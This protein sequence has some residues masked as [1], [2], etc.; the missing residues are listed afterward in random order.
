VATVGTTITPYMQV[1]VQSSV[2]EKNVSMRTYRLE[3]ADVYSGS[4][5]S[6]LI[7]G[8]IIICTGATLFVHHITI[9][10]ADDVARALVPFVGSY[11]KPVF[12]LG[13]FG[14]STLAA[15][16]LP[17][18]TG[19]SLTEAFGLERGVDKPLR[20]APA[21]WGIFTGLI[22]LGAVVGV[23]I[24]RD[25]VV[26][27]LVLVQVVNGVLLPILLV[28]IIRLINNREV[29][30]EYTNGR[31]YNI[32]AWITVVAVAGLSLLMVVTTVLPSLGI[33]LL[34]A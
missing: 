29:M 30:G 26:K 14:A 23:I 3:R 19:Y 9:T 20:A 7:A 11:A 18:A 8:L 32:L 6:N 15:A 2:A 5:F 31:I 10:F 17:L 21:F 27:L 25:A 13:L 22:V 12:A 34:G 28:F 33:H 4:M 16:V 1:Y 24:P